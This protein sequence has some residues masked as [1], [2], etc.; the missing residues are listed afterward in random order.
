MILLVG[1]FLFMLGNAGQLCIVVNPRFIPII[2]C[3]P[4]RIPVIAPLLVID[5]TFRTFLLIVPIF[6]FYVLGSSLF[7]PS[8]I[9]IWA[10]LSILLF[11]LLIIWP[12]FSIL[13]LSGRLISVIESRWMCTLWL[14]FDVFGGHV[15][16]IYT[17]LI[18]K[19]T[20]NL[21]Q[22]QCHGLLRSRI[23]RI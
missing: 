13:W 23:S 7:P 22:C 18:F 10:I 11:L 6:L 20:L 21:E 4:S 9:S 2:V 16:I 3:I 5:S 17:K 1:L 8:F 12:L 19:S 14:L 15:E